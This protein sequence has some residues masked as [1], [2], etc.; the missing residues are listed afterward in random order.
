MSITKRVFVSFDEYCPYQCR[1]CFTYE[2]KRDKIRTIEEI[3]NSIKDETFDVVYVSQKN[4]NFADPQNGIN[5]CKE[6]FQNYKCNLFVITRNVLNL[7]QLM[8]LESIKNGL[9]EINK[10]LFFAVSINALESREICE[11]VTLV[12][13]PMERIDFLR[14]LSDKGFKPILMLRPIF[15]NNII[16]INECLKIIEYAKNYVACVVYGGLGVNS[17]ILKRLGMKATDFSYI[18]NQEYLQGAIECE[19]NFV[20]V[21]KEIKQI[22]EKCRSLNI[23]YFEH[24]MPALNY[25][26]SLP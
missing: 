18:K 3:V 26:Y 22:Q 8:E 24:S 23:P 15:P 21:T 1:H 20:D 9:S 16:P 11:E 13:S 17:D 19:I 10:R 14:R 5:L 6:L 7:N 12:P 4:D 2:I 25:L